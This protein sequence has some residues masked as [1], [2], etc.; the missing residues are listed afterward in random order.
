[1]RTI[2]TAAALLA[3]LALLSGAPASAQAQPV[4]SDED[5]A[6]A[7]AAFDQGVAR[8]RLGDHT[9]ALAAFEQAYRL[10]PAPPVL[11]N[12]G[13]TRAAL[14]RDAA[15][16]QALDRYLSES[17][18]DVPAPRRREVMSL[19]ATLRP[20]IGAVVLELRPEYALVAIDEG[21]ADPAPPGGVLYLA[22]GEH[23]LELQAPGH[24]AQTRAVVVSAGGQTTLTVTLEA[25][26]PPTHDTPLPPAP[27]PAPTL[28]PTP[29]PLPPPAGGGARRDGGGGLPAGA[30]VV[31]GVGLAALATTVVT[32]VLAL[33]AQSDVDDAHEQVRQ[34][35]PVDAAEVE[36]T[37]ARG[38][39][40][41][42]VADVTLGVGVV[43]L[44]VAIVWA[45]T[46]GG[47]GHDEAGAPARVSFDA[48]GVSLRF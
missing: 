40:L 9:A 27:T 38:R 41:A 48:R 14:G 13:K 2:R 28:S 6:R 7:A 10:A 1:M 8:F 47:G 42:T 35:R 18:P 22:P 4:P 44:G 34:G 31:G 30:V 43:A 45:L 17:G 25:S 24:D 16:Y 26:A 32:G 39:T 19:L 36:D 23:A 46:G 11:Y 3:S 33:G 29:A 12:I 20:R 5:R 21:P 37:A 15:A